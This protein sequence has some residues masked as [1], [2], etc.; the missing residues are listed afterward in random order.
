[1]SESGDEQLARGLPY[2]PCVGIMLVNAEGK[3][4]VGQRL[5]RRENSGAAGDFWQMPQGGI[6]EGEDLRTAALRELAEETGIPADRVTV[7][8]QTDEELLYDLPE[9]L[10]GKLWK[11]RFRG[12]RQHWLLLRFRGDD[13]D[14]RLDAHDPA[15]FEAWRWV[16]PDELPDL[17]VPFK[18]E[19]YRS[20]LERFRGLI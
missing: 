5:D 19:V 18:K 16:E 17:I 13:T 14:V 15:E 10:L 1:M 11:G 12:Q 8:A 9:A 6:D 3:V 2:R 20:V 4:F 7:V